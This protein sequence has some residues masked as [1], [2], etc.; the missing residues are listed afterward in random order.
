M[1]A[2]ILTIGAEILAG[3]ILDTNARDLARALKGLGIAVSRHLS[4]PDEEPVIAQAVR[5]AMDRAEVVV[6]TGGLGPTPDD[7]T[8]DGV[9]LA[10][11]VGRVRHDELLPALEARFRS[12]GRRDM[13]EVNLTQITLP[14]GAEALPNPAGTAP[15]F[16]MERGDSV[17]F[18]VPGIPREMR[19]IL[20]GSIVPWLTR[21]RPVRALFT[22]VLKTQG[23]GESDLVT[24]YGKVFDTLADV[25]LAFYPQTPGVNLKLTARADDGPTARRRLEAAERVL[26][27]GLD[28]YIYG[29]DDEDLAGVVGELL[30]RRGWTVATAESCTGGAIAAYLTSVSGSSRYVDRGVVAYSNRAKVEL[31]GVPESL[32]AEHGAVS[33]PVARAM[34]EGLRKRSG[35]DVVV[36]TTGIAGPTGGS[37]EKPVGLVYSAVA[38]PTGVRAFRSNYPGDRATVVERAVR[39]DVNRLRLVLLGVK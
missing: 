18:V 27:E 16:R 9:A 20:E 37:A 12:F 21:H 32:I 6:V 35:V 23:I 7:R 2:E 26:R 33:E 28:T 22:R 36:A 8:R 29:A 15:G 25:D 4:V 1:N 3:D 30:V 14:E 10:F 11:G 34:A 13:P 17:L 19:A 38:A 5:E 24:R 39:T 31:L